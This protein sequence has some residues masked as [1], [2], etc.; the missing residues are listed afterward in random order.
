MQEIFDDILKRFIETGLHIEAKHNIPFD[1][2]DD[3]EKLSKCK[4]SKQV[5]NLY[6]KKFKS[7][8][9]DIQLEESEID[10]GD[11]GSVKLQLLNAVISTHRKKL[12]SIRG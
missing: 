12:Q 5:K 2:K 7:E 9:F 1:F 3:M 6:D 4:N 10:S 11:L 8:A